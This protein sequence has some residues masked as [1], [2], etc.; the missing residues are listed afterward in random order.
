MNYHIGTSLILQ[1]FKPSCECPLCK[2]EKI[3][4][5]NILFQFLNDAVME[6]RHPR[7]REQTR[8]SARTISTCSSRG[9]IS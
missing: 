9:R 4:E 8:V 7:P 2:I 5:E 3:V 6:D 1:E